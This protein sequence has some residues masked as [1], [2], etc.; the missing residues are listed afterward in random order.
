MKLT[1]SEIRLE[2]EFLKSLQ[3]QSILNLK[4]FGSNFQLKLTGSLETLLYDERSSHLLLFNKM[5][6]NFP[7]F[8]VRRISQLY[9]QLP[10]LLFQHE[11]HLRK[12]KN[13]VKMHKP[14]T[15]QISTKYS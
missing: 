15:A 5:F 8:E 7:T 1:S 10:V 13:W 12:P 11:W 6:E 3:N 4:H 9:H 14:A 2:D